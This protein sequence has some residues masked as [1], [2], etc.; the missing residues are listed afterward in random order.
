MYVQA[1]RLKIVAVVLVQLLNSRSP[2]RNA[3]GDFLIPGGLMLTLKQILNSQSPLLEGKKVKLVRHKDSRAEYR[4]VIKDRDALLEYQKEQ[5][6]DVFKDCDYII[7]LS[8]SNAVV[9]FL[10]VCSR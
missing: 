1:S 9:R 5:S 2:E 3:L 10:S 4:H 8:G 6:K 7:S